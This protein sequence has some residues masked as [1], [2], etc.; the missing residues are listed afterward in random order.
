MQFEFKNFE[1]RILNK[2]NRQQYKLYNPIPNIVL[3]VES[4]S[5]LFALYGKLTLHPKPKKKNKKK[6]ANKKII[7][8]TNRYSCTFLKG[9]LVSVQI[10]N[11]S[12][13]NWNETHSFSQN[14]ITVFKKT[15]PK[16]VII[17]PPELDKLLMNDV[18]DI[19]LRYNINIEYSNIYN[20]SLLQ[21]Y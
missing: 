2:C 20:Y 7:Y 17:L 19:I 14:L 12:D 5:I 6:Y 18:C 10:C 9:D 15:F 16:R 3:V 11:T 8:K 21:L 13:I 1:N 4:M